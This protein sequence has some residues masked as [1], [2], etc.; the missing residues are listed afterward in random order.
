MTFNYPSASTAVGDFVPQAPLC[1]GIGE[2]Q[3]DGY[4][5][6]SEVT[7]SRLSLKQAV[8]PPE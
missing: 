8:G 3:G 4:Y 2:R 1:I 7:V 5:E 6:L